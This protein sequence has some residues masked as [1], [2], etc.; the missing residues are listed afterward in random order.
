MTGRAGSF[1]LIRF[2]TSQPLKSPTRLTS[3]TNALQRVLPSWKTARASSPEET[4][5]VAKPAQFSAYSRSACKK[6][7]SST[8]STNGDSDTLPPFQNSEG[9]SEMFSGGYSF[10][11]GRLT[12][13][14]SVEGA[15]RP[16]LRFGRPQRS[17]YRDGC[18][19][20]HRP[21]PA[22]RP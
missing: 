22:R 6:N 19:E 15:R 4:T 13:Y 11:I 7:S 18:A 9:W 1:S 14:R 20:G 21:C 8:T 5:A 10:Q 12:R 17:N 2:A 3:L 16:P